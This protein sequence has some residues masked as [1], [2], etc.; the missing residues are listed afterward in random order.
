MRRA[1]RARRDPVAA[2]FRV[3][4]HGVRFDPDQAHYIGKQLANP[5]QPALVAGTAIIL[6]RASLTMFA[7]ASGFNS[8]NC[9]RQGW[10]HSAEDVAMA[11]CLKELGVYPSDTRGESGAE[12]F[13]VLSPDMLHSGAGPLPQWYLVMSKN[14]EIVKA[15]CSSEAIA[16]HYVTTEQLLWQAPVLEN[17]ECVWLNRT[18]EDNEDTISPK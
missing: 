2:Q 13:M 16:F 5:G 14:K 15:C 18:I 9:T 12:R 1:E 11:L 8:G 6:S 7:K 4:F 3:G 10:Y 17:G